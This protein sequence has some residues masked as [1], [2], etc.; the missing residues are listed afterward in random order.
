M[1]ISFVGKGGSGKSTLSALFINYLLAQ[2]L[3]VLAIDADLNVHLEALLDAEVPDLAQP[4]LVQKLK[5]FVAGTNL[6][7]EPT[8]VI[9]TTPPGKG[10]NLIKLADTD[11]IL[12]E[13]GYTRDN[14]TLVKAGSPLKNDIGI[15]CYHNNIEVIEILLSHLD[16][17]P[18]EFVVADMVAGVDGFTHTMHMQFDRHL[19]VLEPTY[20]SLSVYRQY[21]ELASASGIADSVIL[22]ANKVEDAS[23][24]DFFRENNLTPQY[25]L[26]YTKALKRKGT[27][28][29]DAV[30]DLSEFGKV[31]AKLYAD[32]IK[33]K[34]DKNSRLHALHDLH[35]QNTRK[36]STVAVH[37]DLSTQIDPDFKFN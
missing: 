26:P 9:K 37:G 28:G 5:Q 4:Q 36:K 24:L 32:L 19:F 16:D 17:Q 22:I 3:K 23:D 2:Q 8:K 21:Y 35:L 30:G 6:R 7:V 14:L 27:I 15:R 13:I 29:T 34:P 18:D 11:G 12:S 25:I 33:I 10:S 1:R 31:F 20:E